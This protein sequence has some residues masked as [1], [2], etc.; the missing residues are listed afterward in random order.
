MNLPV[1]IVPMSVCRS[2]KTRGLQHV[3][4]PGTAAKSGCSDGSRVI[5]HKTDEMVAKQR[6]VSG[7]QIAFPL[8]GLSMPKF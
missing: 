3:Q 7:G 1:I 6:T 8:K 2:A 4:L 5:H